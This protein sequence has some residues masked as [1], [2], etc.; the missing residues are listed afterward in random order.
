MTSSETPFAASPNDQ[1]AAWVALLHTDD[2]G[3]ADWLALEAWL[4]ADPAHGPAYNEAEG[5]WAALET[6][7][8]A[9]RAGLDPEA[10]ETG[11]ADGLADL[12][13]R[14]QA[15]MGWRRW[16]LVAAPVAAALVAGLLLAGPWIEGRGVTYVTAPG[17]T[18]EVVLK[19][20]TKIAMNGDSRLT[21]RMTS[22]ARTVEMGQA[23]AAFDVTHDPSRPF[24]IDVGESQV[25]VIGTAFNIRRD[26]ASTRVSVIRG[27]VQVAD[28]QDPARAVRLTVGESVSRDDRTDR[29]VISR[30]GADEAQAWRAGRLIYN[31]RPLAEVA[32]DLSRA[33]ATPVVVAD[34]AA[35]L[36]FTGV[37]ELGDETRVITRLEGFL[38]VR[39]Y[40]AADRIEL[41]RRQD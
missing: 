30:V 37:L 14:R 25:R 26:S 34:D 3:E 31:D 39:A 5:L 11:R 24:L 36:R 13:S 2:A 6:H 38:P 18:R 8:Q 32:T 7:R 15:R 16:S 10:L 35:S 28:L 33:F 41:R 12:A 29:A 23:E 40:R 9:I 17:Q 1:A 4:V 20:G 27:I 21:V 19:D 22:Q